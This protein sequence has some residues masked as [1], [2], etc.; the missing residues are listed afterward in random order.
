MGSKNKQ[1]EDLFMKSLC[2]F[3]FQR[4]NIQ[5]EQNNKIVELNF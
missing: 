2:I 1:K 3:D 4:S 5:I